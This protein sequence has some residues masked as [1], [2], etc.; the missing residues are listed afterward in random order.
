MGEWVLTLNLPESLGWLVVLAAYAGSWVFAVKRLGPAERR[1]LLVVAPGILGLMSCAF[2]VL[3]TASL[4]GSNRRSVIAGI[5]VL[6]WFSSA[7]M[8]LA[9]RTLSAPRLGTLSG[10][11]R[12]GVATLWV[13][14]LLATL[15]ALFAAMEQA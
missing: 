3:F 2:T 15:V 4:V 1:P 7:A 9:G 14:S 13:V 12:A 5:T 10:W 6:L 8:F 11:R